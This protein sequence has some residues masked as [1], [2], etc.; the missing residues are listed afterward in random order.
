MQ[1]LS[2]GGPAVAAALLIPSFGL[3]LLG[4][5]GDAPGEWGRGALIAWTAL[6]AALLAGA[7]LQAGAGALAWA[8]LLL[9]LVAVMTGGP[10]G[11]ILAALAAAALVAA[12][13]AAPS[14][15]WLAL[16]LAAAPFALGL[17]Q[18]TA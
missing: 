16:A 1:F 2:L 18:L 14:P 7:A 15:R 5:M 4:L 6:T 3:A 17:R 8:P 10:P 13:P 12:G 11:L 9:G